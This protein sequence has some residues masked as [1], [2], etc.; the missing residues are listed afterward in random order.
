MVRDIREYRTMAPAERQEAVCEMAKA[1][2]PIILRPA[3][4]VADDDEVNAFDEDI[5]TLDLHTRQRVIV[6]SDGFP[7]FRLVKRMAKLG[8]QVLLLQVKPRATQDWR[9]LGAA[10]V[11]KKERIIDTEEP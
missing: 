8:H 11:S 4:A 6:E 5:S 7:K 3:D 10:R 9:V 1:F 2:G